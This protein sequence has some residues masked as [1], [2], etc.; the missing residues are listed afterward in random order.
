MTLDLNELEHASLMA[1]VGLA[2]SVMQ[3]EEEIGRKFIST[4][5]QPG[6]QE[7]CKSLVERLAAG[8]DDAEH[9]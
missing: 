4:L 1:L 2:V 5:S 6:I 7:V 3:Q 9:H 8:I